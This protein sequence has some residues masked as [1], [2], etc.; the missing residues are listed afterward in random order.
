MCIFTSTDLIFRETEPEGLYLKG[1]YQ[2]HTDKAKGYMDREL[3]CNRAVFNAHKYSYT[4][5]T[6]KQWD[7]V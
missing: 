5:S 1:P 7:Y 4:E 6:G 2:P 3:T